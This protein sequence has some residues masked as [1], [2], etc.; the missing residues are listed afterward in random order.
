MADRKKRYW[1][2]QGKNIAIVEEKPGGRT[3]NY[4]TDH[5][6]SISETGLE[7]RIHAISLDKAS[8]YD[9]IN[10]TP[11]IPTQFHEALVF[12]AIAQLYEDPRQQ[13]LQAAQYFDQKYQVALKNAKKYARSNRQVGGVI[14]P[15]D[16]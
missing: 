3:I 8:N 12:K 5:Y 4:V 6:D 2:I 10:D 7:M 14:K 11:D 13:N 1:Y 9:S 16:F 15:Y